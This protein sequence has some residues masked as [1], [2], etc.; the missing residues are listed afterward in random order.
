MVIGTFKSIHQEHLFYEKKDC[1]VPFQ[2]SRSNHTIMLDN[3]HF[4]APL[5][6]L[7]R[8]A[9]VLVLKKYM[10]HFLK[11]RTAAIKK[12]AERLHQIG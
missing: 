8:L 10:T 7:G 2:S 9:E 5:G 6:I 11:V 3:F 4:E 1:V 12:E